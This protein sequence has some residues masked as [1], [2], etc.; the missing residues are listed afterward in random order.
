MASEPRGDTPDLDTQRTVAGR[1]RPTGPAGWWRWG[2]VVLAALVF[3]LI[4]AQ[5]L[6]GGAPGGTDVVPGTPVVAPD[7]PPPVAPTM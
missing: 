5:I 1:V 4:V 7:V 2:L 6:Q 3:V